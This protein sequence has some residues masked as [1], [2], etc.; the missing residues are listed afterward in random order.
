MTKEEP[1]DF[2]DSDSYKLENSEV[3]IVSELMKILS[4]YKMLMQSI[5]QICIYL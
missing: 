5:S 1:T 2:C 4:F 3:A